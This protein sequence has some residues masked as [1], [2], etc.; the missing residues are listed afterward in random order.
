MTSNRLLALGL[1]ISAVSFSGCSR[2]DV[3][4]APPE[5]TLS[6][7]AYKGH[8]ND[9][10]MNHL[11]AAF[12]SI[13][14]SRLDDCQSCHAGGDVIV[15]GRAR[16]KN[17]CD[18]CHLVPFP[19]EDAEGAPATFEETLNPFGLAYSRAGR[20]VEALRALASRDCPR[21]RRWSSISNG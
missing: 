1:A 20:S 13:V 6:S 7:R 2:D 14:G 16:F 4:S 19:V 17:A 15:R 11:V 10:D 12:P 21:R 9:L 5:T 8:A 3:P 18:Y